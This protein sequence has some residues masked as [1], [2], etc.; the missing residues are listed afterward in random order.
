MLLR[1]IRSLINTN[2]HHDDKAIDSQKFKNNIQ[3]ANADLNPLDDIKRAAHIYEASMPFLKVKFSNTKITMAVP[4]DKCL[5]FALSLDNREPMTNKWILTFDQNDVFF[6]IGSNNG[7]YGLMA[8]LVVG[9]RV[10]A[11]EPHFASYHVL[12]RNVYANNL[13]E[14]MMAYPLALSDG[15]GFENLY[16]SAITAGKSLNNFGDARPSDNQIWNA[17]IPQ[18]A[19]SVSLDEFVDICGVFPNHIKIDVDGIEH[20]I[21]AGG[22]KTLSDKNVKSVLIEIDEK[23]PPHLIIY[24]Q[25]KNFGF[26]RFVKDEAGVFFYRN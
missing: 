1:L 24:E 16:L 21:V 17:V 8:A 10:Y 13:Q 19:I 7:I 25:M 18:P 9:C 2:K 22:Q 3:H 26:T 11:F 4:N 23:S 5:Y 6:D 20:K 15:L 12:M 14:Q